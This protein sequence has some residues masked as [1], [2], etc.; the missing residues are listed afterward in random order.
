MFRSLVTALF[1]SCL[2]IF[3]I[4]TTSAWASIFHSFYNLVN[5]F[6]GDILIQEVIV[7]FYELVVGLWFDS[8]DVLNVVRD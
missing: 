4:Y 7:V 6:I 5:V 2:S 3:F 1:G 8:V